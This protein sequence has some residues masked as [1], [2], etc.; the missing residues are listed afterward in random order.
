MGGSILGGRKSRANE[1]DAK[2]TA[3]ETDQGNDTSGPRIS[4][5][6]K[7]RGQQERVHDTTNTAGCGRNSGGEA[8]PGFKVVTDGSDRRGEEEG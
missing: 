2:H 3:A 4:Y 8:A 5:L 6:I 1:A 7:E